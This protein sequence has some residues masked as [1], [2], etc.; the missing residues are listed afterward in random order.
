MDGVTE[1]IR[2]RHA[3]HCYL[4]DAEY[5]TRLAASLGVDLERVAALA[6]MTHQ[7]R[8]EATRLQRG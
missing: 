5:G 6:G 7:E 1:N 4:A 2:L 8:M 3:A